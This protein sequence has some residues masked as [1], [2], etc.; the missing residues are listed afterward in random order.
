[1]IPSKAKDVAG[2]A[3]VARV[4]ASKDVTTNAVLEAVLATL[5]L[6]SIFVWPDGSQVKSDGSTSLIPIARMI[7]VASWA[8]V[9]AE[10][11]GAV[12]EVAVPVVA[13]V[14]ALIGLT[15]SKFFILNIDPVH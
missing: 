3:T 2:A 5:V 13:A 7:Y 9:I 8:G 12:V 11:I 15:L 4:G 14:D 10:N 6:E 1:M